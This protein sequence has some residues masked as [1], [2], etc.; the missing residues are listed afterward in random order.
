MATWLSNALSSFYLSLSLRIQ[1]VTKFSNSFIPSSPLLEPPLST[2]T[3]L[4]QYLI[5][6]FFLVS[7]ITDLMDMNLSKYQEISEG[8]GAWRAAVRG[9]AE[10][11]TWLRLKATSFFLNFQLFD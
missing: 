10:N 9:A 11:Q 3:I 1:L 5:F 4:V 8:V 6:S 7:N 2:A